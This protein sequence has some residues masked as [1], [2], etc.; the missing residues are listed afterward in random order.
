MLPI[1]IK[2]FRWRE[3]VGRK[4]CSS[5]NVQ[6][7]SQAAGADEQVENFEDGDD[8]DEEEEEEEEEAPVLK[9]ST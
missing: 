5:T 8:F 3:N 9:V 7:I 6:L 1:L 4:R 2:A